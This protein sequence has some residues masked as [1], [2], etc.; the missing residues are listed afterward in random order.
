MCIHTHT[1]RGLIY[2]GCFNAPAFF[3]HSPVSL[4]SSDNQRPSPGATSSGRMS[5]FHR[6]L[7]GKEVGVSLYH[8]PMV[9]LRR[10][11]GGDH[12]TLCPPQLHEVLAESDRTLAVVKDLFGDDP[13]VSTTVSS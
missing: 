12:Q 2:T 7:H 6:A 11:V 1:H 9:E 10:G 8:L 13:K 5:A 4:D 3:S